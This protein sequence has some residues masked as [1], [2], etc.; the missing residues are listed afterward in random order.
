MRL[1]RPEHDTGE[2]LSTAP[3]PHGDDSA[4]L[5][6][7]VDHLRREVTARSMISMAEGALAVLGQLPIE[8]AAAVLRDLSA[9]L[10]LNL[11]EVAEHVLGLVQGTRT[12][13]LVVDELQRAL[14]RA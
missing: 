13:A 12:P 2:P 11:H 3:H 14:Q 7:E 4:R 10:G 6:A 5:R 1:D 9:A 8:K